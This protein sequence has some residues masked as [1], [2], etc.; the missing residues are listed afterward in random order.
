MKK[1]SVI[2]IITLLM[3]ALVSFGVGTVMAQDDIKNDTF[4]EVNSIQMTA[5]VNGLEKGETAT[6]RLLLDTDDEIEKAFL[7]K[8]IEGNG[9]RGTT[10]NISTNL[11]DGY[12]Q[13]LIE[14]PSK[15]FRSPKGYCF[16]VYESQ[17]LNPR[18]RSLDLIFELIP[19]ARQDYPPCR[20]CSVPKGAP[21]EPDPI[22]DEKPVCAMEGLI[23]LSAPAKQPE[24][25]D[26]TRADVYYHPGPVTY[27]D[28]KGVW[29]RSTVVNSD[30]CHNCAPTVQMIAERVMA[31]DDGEWIEAGWAEGSWRASSQFVYQYNTI[32]GNWYYYNNVSTND[33][34]QVR[35]RNSSGNN[36]RAEYWNGYYWYLLEGEKD[37]GFSTATKAENQGE[38]FTNNGVN[39][40]YPSSNF[41]VGYIFVTYWDYWD[42]SYTT[43]NGSADPYECDFNT[44]YYDFDVYKD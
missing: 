41:D 13:L 14:A 43:V 17:I 6:L 32:D 22:A 2:A 5:T 16:Q 37:L 23:G 44:Q 27:T 3:A 21:R 40:S 36:W 9:D 28:N 7:E 24:T 19:P 39:P 8:T 15:Y 38:V 18:D 11:K 30:V 26:G 31:E 33:E 34:V 20:E 35:V 29:G 10:V 42:T 4:T 25:K 1:S 12:Y